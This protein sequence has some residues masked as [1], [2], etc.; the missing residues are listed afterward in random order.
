MNFV[1]VKPRISQDE[2]IQCLIEQFPM[3]ESELQD[4]DYQGLIYLQV[5][6]LTRYA[7]NCL[8]VGRFDEL[9]KNN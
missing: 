4:E 2:F 1:I 6:C 9:K 7:N 8:S 5:A 3:L